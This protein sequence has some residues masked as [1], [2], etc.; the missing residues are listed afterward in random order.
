MH[1]GSAQSL[2]T[3]GKPSA[4]CQAAVGGGCE[5]KTQQDRIPAKDS[6]CPQGGAFF[7][8][9]PGESA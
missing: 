5:D 8:A 6:V 3:C 4:V 2:K 7:R 1:L 9:D